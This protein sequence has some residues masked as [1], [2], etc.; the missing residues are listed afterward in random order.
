M[1][2][3]FR[4]LNFQ[5]LSFAAVLVV[6]VEAAAILMLGKRNVEESCRLAVRAEVVPDQGQGRDLDPDLVQDHVLGQGQ[7]QSPDPDQGVDLV[8]DPDQDR[9]Q[10]G[11]GVDHPGG[12]V[13]D[14]AP[15]RAVNLPTGPEAGHV[16]DLQ[17]DL[18]QEVGHGPE[19]RRRVE[20][21]RGQEMD[22]P[23]QGQGHEV[24][25]GQGQHL[26]QALEEEV[27]ANPEMKATKSLAK[28]SWKL[29]SKDRMY[30]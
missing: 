12:S 14:P 7:D 10:D 18:D 8:P 2:Y 22:R 6:E 20:D 21:L 9:V 29:V 5:C 26:L 11:L 13:V 4:V 23:G 3:A 25:Q 30:I 15:G 19:R 17:V 28:N 1:V 16:P 24:A 27:A